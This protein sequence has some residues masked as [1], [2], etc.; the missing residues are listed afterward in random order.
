MMQ[1]RNLGEFVAANSAL[2]MPFF[3][4]IYA[5]QQG[6]I[7]YLFGGRQPVRQGG[8]WSDYA[9]ILPGNDPKAL[10]TAT[11]PW[12]ALPRA[13]DPPGGFVANSNNPP[14]TS[15]FP[16]VIDPANFPSY[17][18]PNFTALR[19]QNAALFLLSIPELTTAQVLAGKES[20]HML[21]ADRVLPD[22]IAAAQASGDAIAQKAASVLAFW[23]RTADAASKGGVLFERWFDTAIADPAM[24]KDDT[25]NFYSP[26]PKFRIGWSAE[27]PLS[28]PVGLADPA[29]AVVDLVAAAQAV[30]Q[31]YGALDIAWGDVHRTVLVTHDPL[32]QQAI[33]VSNQPESGP[34]DPFGPVR[35]VNPFPAQDGTQALWSYGGDGYVQLVEFAPD[36]AHAQ[37]LLGYGNASRPGSPHITDQLSLF[38][39]KTLRPAWRT[40]QEVEQ[41]TVSRERF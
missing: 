34:D 14:W 8:T 25:I 30:Q 2:Q 12:S 24:P 27:A 7:M 38:N 3:N 33:P 36:G 4:V 11:F 29:Q 15:T 6:Q 40:R 32:F 10:W 16:E 5:D 31:A 1:A 35:V 37:A 28:T 39:A 22:L 20:T 13:I 17:V 23:D 9:G 18:A 19:P 21:L 41:H 26:Y